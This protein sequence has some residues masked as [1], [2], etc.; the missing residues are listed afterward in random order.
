M[1]CALVV[2]DSRTAQLHLKRMLARYDLEAECVSSAQEA[3]DY[4]EHKS[5]PAVI[6]LDH[7]MEDMDG[8]EALKI[9]KANPAT[10]TIPVIMYTAQQGDV[11]VGQARALGALDILSKGNMKPHQLGAVL[12]SLGIHDISSDPN[13]PKT[14]EEQSK[15]EQSNAEHE[16]AR[17][18]AAATTVRQTPPSA[19]TTDGQFWYEPEVSSDSQKNHKQL[20]NE[21]E[22]QSTRLRE[23]IADESHLLLG[24]I[25]ST[26]SDVQKSL[27]L[28]KQTGEQLGDEPVGE[29]LNRLSRVQHHSNR[30]SGVMLTV[31]LFGFAFGTYTLLQTQAQLH[32]TQVSLSDLQSRLQQQTPQPD[33]AYKSTDLNDGLSYA[34][35]DTISWAMNSDFT[36]GYGQQAFNENR[37]STISNLI[38]RLTAAGFEGTVE[39]SVNSGNFCLQ[40][41]ESGNLSLAADSTPISNCI[42][43][44]DTDPDLSVQQLRSVPFVNFEQSAV[45]VKDGRIGLQLRSDG[46]QAPLYA[47]PADFEPVTAAQ[48]NAIAA[49]NNRIAISFSY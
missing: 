16:A 23:Q 13:A 8:F 14:Q 4:L 42:L 29:L 37:V 28:L 2:D 34:L 47:Y 33:A 6:F 41:D 43:L 15:S 36:F 48:W 25:H 46:F 18:K 32:D 11:Y 26:R 7:H 21:Y 12:H 35:V 20:L 17:V 38:Y 22:R 31:M 39:L 19:A 30:L 5:A 40:A 27:K 3:L 44:Q 1:K 9:I 45:P 10:A 24:S 49:K